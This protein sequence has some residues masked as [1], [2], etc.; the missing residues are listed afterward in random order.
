MTDLYCRSYLQ[1]FALFLA[2]GFSFLLA[3]LTEKLPIFIGIIFC[4]FFILD[5]IVCISKVKELI[6]RLGSH[7]KYVIKKLDGLK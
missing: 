6:S 2:I 7:H 3:V 4:M 1:M 5:A